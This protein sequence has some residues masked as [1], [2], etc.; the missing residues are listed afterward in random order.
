MTSIKMFAKTSIQS[1]TDRKIFIKKNICLV[2]K[3][4]KKE[5][6][7]AKFAFGTDVSRLL[8]FTIVSIHEYV[9]HCLFHTH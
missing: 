6:K 4:F 2:P 3:E 5:S 1:D 9:Y 7:N 8:H